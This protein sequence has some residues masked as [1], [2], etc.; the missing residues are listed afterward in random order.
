MPGKP[1]CFVAYP[2]NPPA[3]AETIE[4]SIEQ[5]QQGHVVDIKG[6]KSTS[7]SGNFIITSICKS[8]DDSDIFICD[9]TTLNHNVLF[10][11][12]YAI[13]RKKRVWIVFD[14]NIEESKGDYERSKLFTTIGYSPYSNSNDIVQCFYNDQ[15]YN[16]RFA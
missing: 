3:L 4:N 15:P 14:P 16:L 12:G 11:L 10:E 9:L 8:I 7:V 6:W 13:A 1:S 5:I 2:S